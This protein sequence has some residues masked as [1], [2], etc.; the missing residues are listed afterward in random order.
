[1]LECRDVIQGQSVT[2]ANA[3]QWHFPTIKRNVGFEMKHFTLGYD[4]KIIPKKIKR[5]FFTSE[6]TQF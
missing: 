5:I 6:V 1:M 2:K 4:K 3:V